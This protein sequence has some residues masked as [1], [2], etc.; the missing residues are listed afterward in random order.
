MKTIEGYILKKDAADFALT[1]LHLNHYHH[2]EDVYDR[3]DR[4][5][6]ALVESIEY[7]VWIKEPHTSICK[8]ARCEHLSFMTTPRCGYCGARM[9]KI[10]VEV[11]NGKFEEMRPLW[12]RD[13]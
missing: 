2:D 6:S 8:C 9:Q 10:M 11:D 1:L 12:E 7:S 4:L 5:P 3:F 13:S